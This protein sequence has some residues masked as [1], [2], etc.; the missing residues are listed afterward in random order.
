MSRKAKATEFLNAGY[1]ICVTGR[2]MHVTDAMKDYAMEK[3]SKI[4]RL[5]SRIID[6]NITMDI[7]K[8]NQ[9]VDII[10]KVNNIQIKSSAACD[11]MYISIDRA[12]EKME[13]Q[14]RRYKR[15]LQDHQA[16]ALKEID[17]IVNVIRPPEEEDLADINLD[18]EEENAREIVERYRPQQFVSSETVSLKTLSTDEAIMRL[19]LSGDL[20][21]VYRNIEDRR[22]KI[23]Y[24]RKDGNFAIMEPE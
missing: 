2:H 21:L 17:M 9:Q 5:S 22:L 23:A 16:I 15:K 19:E 10:L 4:E 12:V 7:Q 14:L 20:F 6:V 18:I 8:L 3:V 24:R 11:N 1:N 13:H